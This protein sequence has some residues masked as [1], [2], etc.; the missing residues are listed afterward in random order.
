MREPAEFTGDNHADN[1]PKG[2]GQE[3]LTRLRQQS[4]WATVILFSPLLPTLF[5][6]LPTL[7][8]EPFAIPSLL[9]G[10]A[11]AAYLQAQL[12]RRLASNHRPFEADQLFCTLGAA[13]WITIFRAGAVVALACFLPVVVLHNIPGPHA[14]ELPELYDLSWIAGIM[15]LGISLADLLDG[16]IARKQGRNTELG[17]HLDIETDAAGLLAASLLAITLDRLPGI[18]LL[19]GLAYYVFIFSIRQRQN[20]G[21]PMVVLQ[22]RPYARIIAGCQMGLVATALLPIFHRSFTFLAAYIFM[23]PLLIGFVR[24]WL[25]VSCRIITDARQQTSLDSIGRSVVLKL[26]VALRLFLLASGMVMLSD[27]IMHQAQL[28]RHAAHLMLFSCCLLTGV[29]IIGRSASLFLILLLACNQSPFG[30]SSSTLIVFG[31][32]AALMLTGTGIMSLWAPEER[33]LYRR[34]KSNLMPNSETL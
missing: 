34:G 23:T 30:I 29:G 20:R 12:S 31:A 33:I 27:S 5:L 17:K 1:F 4:W 14:R 22:S 19:V 26:P 9:P 28:S 8:D 24:D 25:V 10:P 6:C 18:Y 21:L 15:Y 11:I 16:L 2:N 7:K 3:P 32:A 13:N